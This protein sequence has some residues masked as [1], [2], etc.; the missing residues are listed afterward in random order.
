MRSEN[1]L[2]HTDNTSSFRVLRAPIHIIFGKGSFVKSPQAP[3]HGAIEWIPKC[4]GRDVE[5]YFRLSWEI[6]DNIRSY[7]SS[8]PL[9]RSPRTRRI[10]DG[11]MRFSTSNW[12]A[13]HRNLHNCMRIIVSQCRYRTTYIPSA[14]WESVSMTFSLSFSIHLRTC[15]YEYTTDLK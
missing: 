8:K 6:P 13:I 14:F 10:V 11:R 1:K 7:V 15:R 3:R 2:E 4:I 5:R 12:Q 9:G